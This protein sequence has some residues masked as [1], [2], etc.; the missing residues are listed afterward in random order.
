MTH[1]IVTE[2]QSDLHF[3]SEAEGGV[4][5]LDADQSVGGKGLGLRPK[6]LMLVSL[7]GCTGMDVASLLKKMR[8][9]VEDFRVEVVAELTD[10]HPKVYKKVVVHY[11]FSDKSYKKDKIEKAVDLSVNRYCGVFE[12]FRGFADISYQIHYA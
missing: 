7:S 6:Q 3:V 1:K 12:M 4:V 2:W 5:V 9:E 10:E 11:Y 8:A